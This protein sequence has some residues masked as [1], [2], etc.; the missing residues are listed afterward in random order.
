MCNWHLEKHN[1]HIRHR[2]IHKFGNTFGLMNR[3]H[4]LFHIDCKILVLMEHFGTIW[5]CHV[6]DM[7]IVLDHNDN[8]LENIQ[9][10]CFHNK[11]SSNSI[12]KDILR[13]NNGKSNYFRIR[14]T[15]ITS[16]I[17]PISIWTTCWTHWTFRFSIRTELIFCGFQWKKIFFFFGWNSRFDRGNFHLW[18]NWHRLI[19]WRT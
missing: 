2:M 9:N 18:E 16:G 5:N 19:E 12:W 13:F 4:L 11:S 14:T 1:N 8:Y 15:R 17:I 10:H 7:I 6:I 3:Q